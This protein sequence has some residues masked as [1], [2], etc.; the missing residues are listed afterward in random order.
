[1]HILYET[2]WSLGWEAGSLFTSLLMTEIWNPVTLFFH[3]VG[4]RRFSLIFAYL[5]SLH[6]LDLEHTGHIFSELH[7]SLFWVK[8]EL[9]KYLTMYKD[10]TQMLTMRCS[11]I[12]KKHV[13]FFHFLKSNTFGR[14]RFL[15]NI[16][17]MHLHYFK[18]I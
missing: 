3:T 1:M 8:Y 17:D 16:D 5:E 15:P 9:C 14:L 18:V 2:W 12:F 4:A 10:I 13:I 7:V 11:F 6:F